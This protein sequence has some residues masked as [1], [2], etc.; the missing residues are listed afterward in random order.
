MQICACLFYSRVTDDCYIS[1]CF[2]SDLV[3]RPAL[4]YSLSSL[5]VSLPLSPSLPSLRPL[6]LEWNADTTNKLDFS[7]LLGIVSF[8][9]FVRFPFVSSHPSHQKRDWIK[10]QWYTHT[11]SQTHT[12]THTHTHIYIYWGLQNSPTTLRLRQSHPR[13]I[14]RPGWYIKHIW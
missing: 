14:M 1:D 12:H 5:S 7:V 11:H 9:I 2:T 10:N 13:K 8:C 3:L 4:F 6:K